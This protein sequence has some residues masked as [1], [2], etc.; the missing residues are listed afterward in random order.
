MVKSGI[1]RLGTGS[2]AAYHPLAP[3]ET[4]LTK[5]SPLSTS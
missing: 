3:L 4:E 1:A 2:E 5:F